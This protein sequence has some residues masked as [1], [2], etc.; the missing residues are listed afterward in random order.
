MTGQV[1]QHQIGAAISDFILEVFSRNRQSTRDT[2]KEKR[3]VI[4]DCD[5]Y[6]VQ[7]I[8]TTQERL[9]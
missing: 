5:R 2:R 3:L 9:A 1:H 4:A 8:P 7:V 6:D